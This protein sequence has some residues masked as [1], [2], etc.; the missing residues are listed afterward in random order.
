MSGF[1]SY[2]TFKRQRLL[3]IVFIVYMSLSRFA[4]E[5]DDQW[6]LSVMKLLLMVEE[7]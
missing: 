1:I 5:Y 7:Y 4:F 3:Y 2:I 6:S